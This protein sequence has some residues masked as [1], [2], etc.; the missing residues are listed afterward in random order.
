VRLQGQAR[1]VLFFLLVGGS[2]TAVYVLL[3]VLFTV[4][5]GLRPSLAVVLTL[6]LVL[7]PTYLM[8]RSYTFQSQRSHVSAFSR[9]AATQGMSNGVAIVGAE[10]FANAILARPWI[11]FAVITVIVASLNYT[12]LKTWAFALER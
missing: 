11:G 10:V 6:A 3:G 9:Y 2:S 7:L 12:L 1:E 8:Q 5:V 4:V